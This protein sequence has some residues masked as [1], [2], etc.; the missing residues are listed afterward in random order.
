M[1]RIRG[2]QKEV[3]SEDIFDRCDR[4]PIANVASTGWGPTD[5]VVEQMSRA[6]LAEAMGIECCYLD[7]SF[8]CP[9]EGSCDGGEC[10]LFPSNR[11]ES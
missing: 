2:I 1:S 6:I 10:L 11:T 3:P 7:G 5:Y 8:E 4:R 9:F